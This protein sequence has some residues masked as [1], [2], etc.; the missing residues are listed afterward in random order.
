MNNIE[1]DLTINGIKVKT[2]DELRENLTD[3]LVMIAR[4]GQLGQWL[5]SQSLCEEAK[6]VNHAVADY[7]GNTELFE[8]ICAVIG[9]EGSKEEIAAL[10]VPP[11]LADTKADA[12]R[13]QQKFEAL[14]HV[15]N[16]SLDLLIKQAF[17]NAETFVRLKEEILI[18]LEKQNVAEEQPKKK[19][20]FIVPECGELM[21]MA[22]ALT[23]VGLRDSCLNDIQYAQEMSAKLK[24]KCFV[25]IGQKVI[26]GDFFA[27]GKVFFIP[28]SGTIREINANYALLELE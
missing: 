21:P 7:T 3:E 23:R 24:R 10:F 20:V 13:Y 5:R 1:I 11:A 2:L 22:M 15:F 19:Y 26:L 18:L 28:C 27:F 14:H 16:E 17:T 25:N 12:G 4:S 6:K 8:A 9:V